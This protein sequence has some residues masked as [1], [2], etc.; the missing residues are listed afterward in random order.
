M[1]RL[2]LNVSLFSKVYHA[3]DNLTIFGLFKVDVGCDLF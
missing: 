3:K 2:V 1:R